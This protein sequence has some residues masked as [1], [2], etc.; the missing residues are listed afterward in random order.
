MAAAAII[1]RLKGAKHVPGFEVE[2]LVD[3]SR[4]G[5]SQVQTELLALVLRSIGS[6]SASMCTSH[7]GRKASRNPLPQP[8]ATPCA[9]LMPGPRALGS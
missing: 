7:E 1:A 5:L 3:P 8:N 6:G 9:C 4:T 2:G